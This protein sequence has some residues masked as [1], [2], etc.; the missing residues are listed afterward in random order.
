MF[1]NLFFLLER[2]H[3]LEMEPSLQNEKSISANSEHENFVLLIKKN[4]F[5]M[6]ARLENQS[7]SIKSLLIGKAS[8]V[9]Y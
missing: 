3:S 7:K 9:T 5:K 6:F 8:L 1:K 2:S 4:K